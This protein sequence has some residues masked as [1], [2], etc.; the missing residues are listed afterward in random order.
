MEQ[1]IDEASQ[2]A[3]LDESQKENQK[4]DKTFEEL[5]ELK[6]NYQQLLK[7]YGENYPN[8]LLSQK[9]PFLP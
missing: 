3:T 9:E 5:E 2:Q 8:S 4:I 1:N 7:K 6:T